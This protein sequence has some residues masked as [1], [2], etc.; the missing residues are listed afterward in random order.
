MVVGVAGKRTLQSS[1]RESGPP[2]GTLLHVQILVF[3]FGTLGG[4]MKHFSQLTL[5]KCSL[6]KQLENY[7]E[8]RTTEWM[9][10]KA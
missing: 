9:P 8:M 5:L 1:R 10:R 4:Q 3:M 6:W 2:D 7:F